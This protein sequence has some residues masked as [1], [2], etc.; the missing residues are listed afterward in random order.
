MMVASPV[1]L[2]TIMQGGGNSGV[3][4]IRLGGVADEGN[5][6]SL[7]LDI[8]LGERASQH[9]L[10]TEVG[11]KVIVGCG[12]YETTGTAVGPCAVSHT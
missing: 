6:C 2:T 3:E 1:P 4:G 12:G 7:G 5:G 9:A 11:M 10:S 8:S